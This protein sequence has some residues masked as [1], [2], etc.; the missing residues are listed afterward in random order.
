MEEE[1]IYSDS[2]IVLPHGDFPTVLNYSGTQLSSPTLADFTVNARVRSLPPL[3]ETIIQPIF[4][5]DSIFMFGNWGF[6]W[7]TP[8]LK[9]CRMGLW[10]KDR[11]KFSLSLLV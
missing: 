11:K 10:I 4:I 9:I 6:P 5:W 8:Y 3:W 2:V 7:S 1:V